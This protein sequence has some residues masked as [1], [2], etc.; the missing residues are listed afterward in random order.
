MCRPVHAWSLGSGV[1]NRRHRHPDNWQMFI[2]CSVSRPVSSTLHLPPLTPH[3]RMRSQ[4]ASLALLTL[5]RARSQTLPTQTLSRL[6]F[7][8]TPRT[9]KYNPINEY[10]EDALNAPLNPIQAGT[11]TVPPPP[12]PPPSERPPASRPLTGPEEQALKAQAIF[13][14][15]DPNERK[16]ELKKASTTIAGVLVPPKPDEPDNCCMSGCVNCVWDRYRDELEDWA[17]ASKEARGK[18]QAQ[19]AAAKAASDAASQVASSMDDDGGGSETNWEEDSG[20]KD[21]FEGVPV[22]I[23]EFMKIEKRLKEQ[24]KREQSAG[25]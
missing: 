10:A 12:I 24:H 3:K 4:C 25:G 8:S 9:P 23:R 2:S 14:A 19:R 13:G 20:E 18:L 21:L 1:K 5:K 17:A 22:G 16:D 15:R 7:S 11:K 6:A